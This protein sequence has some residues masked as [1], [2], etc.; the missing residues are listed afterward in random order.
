MNRLAHVLTG[1]G[2]AAASSV[3]WSQNET[4][5]LRYG[6]I[7]PLHSARVT[8]MGGSFG[9]LGADLSCMGINP[10]GLGMYRR[11]DL[12]LTAGIHG[13]GTSSQWNTRQQDATGVTAVASNFGV[14]LTYP[15]VDADWPFFTLAVG[16]Q[17]RMPFAQ[18]IDLDG[19]PTGNSVSD[20]FVWQAIDD[21]GIY[22]Y[23]STDDA[24]SNG[25][26]FAYGASLAWRTGLLLPD[27]DDLYASA[28]GGSVLVDRQIQREGRMA[29]TQIAF[30]T[31]FQDK[32]SIGATLG[33]PK[34]TFEEQSV[35]RE[36]A[37]D[38]ASDLREW[39]FEETLNVSGKGFLLRLGALMR[40]SDAMR[41]GLAHQTRG[42]LTLLDTYATGIRTSWV[43]DSEESATSPTSN[44]EYLL[45]TPDRTTVSTSFL[46]GKFGVINADYVRS[47][48]RRGELRDSESFLSSGYDFAA[49]NEAVRNGY[50]VT[51]QAR[52]GLE[53]RLGDDKQ[54]RVRGGGGM[55]TSPFA[56]DAVA[57]D[58]NRYHASV[59]GGYRIGNVHL[60]AA[61][62]TAWHS[63]DYYF[64]GAFS[65]EP[66][67]QLQRR[68]ST[69]LVSAGLRL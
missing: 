28:V 67:G 15:S 3:I 47:D 51:H 52:V 11:G 1:V 17:N 23:E 46:M 29:E 42:R 55:A 53:M 25:D 58:A 13:A 69:F 54:Y 24:L 7:D 48:M 60:S 50:Q 40:I 38:A 14:A 41:V 65:P 22:G 59:G 8:A 19:V 37:V 32:I 21:A 36:A 5:V 39:R 2:L 34:V 61:W 63:E 45:F 18:R 62:R 16:H 9:A 64:M 4:D 33:L 20:L 56:G 57:A 49:E 10:A 35:H 27:N 12:A 31:T 43:D 66:P 68:A 44:S 6:W 30:G 26:I